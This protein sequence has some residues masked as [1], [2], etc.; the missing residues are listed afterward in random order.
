[1]APG[2]P[3]DHSGQDTTW[4]IAPSRGEPQFTVGFKPISTEF[5]KTQVREVVS[6]V[7]LSVLEGLVSNESWKI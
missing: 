3:V 6:M 2:N 4:G 7:K 5:G 1:M